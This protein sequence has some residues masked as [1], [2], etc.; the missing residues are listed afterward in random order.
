MIVGGQWAS[1]G[2]RGTLEGAILPT[3]AF[4]PR[5]RTQNRHEPQPEPNPTGPKKLE[6]SPGGVG[7]GP[8]VRG[9]VRR[10][11][12]GWRPPGYRKQRLVRVARAAR[13]AARVVASA[14]AEQR[15]EPER[16]ELGRWRPAV[17]R[18][19]QRTMESFPR[20]KFLKN[21]NHALQH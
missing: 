3:A 20:K 17:V 18:W 2:K 7:R 13:T 10:A 12:I 8:P 21:L 9:G 14:R 11:L 4:G 1:P 5:I 15:P 6:M 16:S 19:E